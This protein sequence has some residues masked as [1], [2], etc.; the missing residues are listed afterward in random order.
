MTQVREKAEAYG[1][2]ALSEAE[3]IEFMFGSKITNRLKRMKMAA[4]EQYVRSRRSESEKKATVRS[5]RNIYDLLHSRFY[6]LDI[7]QFCVVL[8]NRSNRVLKIFQA[9]SGGTAGTVVDVS[10]ILRE[11]INTPRCCAIVLAHNHPSNGVQP[12]QADI[13]LTKRFKEAAELMDITLVDHVIFQS[14]GPEYYS[15]ADE[16]ML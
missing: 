14:S 7:E 5:S 4:L 13:K 1:I 15:F 10:V 11:A 3:L 6:E 12:S 9:S 2:P 16:G 8:M